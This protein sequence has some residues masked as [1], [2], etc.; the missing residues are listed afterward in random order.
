[1]IWLEI[2]SNAFEDRSGEFGGSAEERHKHA[3]FQAVIGLCEPQ[4]LD[5]ASREHPM[6]IPRDDLLTLP[7][8]AS[9]ISSS[10]ASPPWFESSR[11]IQREPSSGYSRQIPSIHGT[12]GNRVFQTKGTEL[13][14]KSIEL[15]TD[16]DD[17]IV[18]RRRSELRQAKPL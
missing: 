14:R 4:F 9:W 11:V 7:K 8:L 13:A 18:G 2:E 3:Y 16:L 10:F 1:M 5:W 15:P 17:G 6:A 12:T